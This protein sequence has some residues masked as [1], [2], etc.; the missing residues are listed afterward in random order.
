MI[1]MA[2]AT[3]NGKSIT[4]VQKA[5][6]DSGT[7]VLVGP[8]TDV[9]SVAESVGA[10]EVESGEYEV[11][12][13]T[14]LPDLT[15]TLGSGSDTQALVV[16]GETWKVKVCEFD[17]ICTCLLGMSGMDIPSQDGGPLWILGDVLMRDYFTVFDVGNLQMGFAAA[18]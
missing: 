10:T 6:I 13:D 9:A 1:A 12:C 16:S 8:T 3:M 14:T 18:A 5:I 15:F 7:S 4:T 11:D 17:V 2:S